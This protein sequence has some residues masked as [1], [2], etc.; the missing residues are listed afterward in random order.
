MTKLK[1]N[2]L[3]KLV[4]QVS[5]GLVIIGTFLLIFDIIDIVL[6]FGKTETGL[7][8]SAPNFVRQLMFYGYPICLLTSFILFFWTRKAKAKFDTLTKILFLL[9]GL[10]VILILGNY[11]AKLIKII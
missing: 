3:Y 8:D 11:V 5:F 7:W 2:N 9:N 10:I 6:V 1:I 4:N